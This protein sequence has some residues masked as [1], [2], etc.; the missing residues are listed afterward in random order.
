MALFSTFVMTQNRVGADRKGASDL[1]RELEESRFHLA[2]NFPS[3]FGLNFSVMKRELLVAL[4]VAVLL[5]ASGFG[6]TP[7][8]VDLRRTRFS[9]LSMEEQAKLRSA[10]DMA[11]RDPALAQSRARYEQARKEFRDKLHDALL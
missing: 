8:G 7:S 1:H 6:Q 9:H 10:H 3:Y 5:P 2:R 4:W 11:M